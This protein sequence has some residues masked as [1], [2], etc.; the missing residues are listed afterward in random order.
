MFGCNCCSLLSPSST[1]TKEKCLVKFIYL[2][3]F[4]SVLKMCFSFIHIDGKW[5]ELAI[6]VSAESVYYLYSTD[7]WIKAILCSSS[8]P[9]HWDGKISMYCRHHLLPVIKLISF[10][11]ISL[12][13]CC[14]QCECVIS[15]SN[16]IYCAA[17]FPKNHMYFSNCF[18]NT[19]IDIFTKKKCIFL[20]FSFIPFSG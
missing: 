16:V 18:Q 17:L 12:K 3:S 2:I 11:L 14:K 20:R 15:A 5:P 4:C 7:F 13:R 6:C 19:H 10:Q 1:T 8:T 9:E